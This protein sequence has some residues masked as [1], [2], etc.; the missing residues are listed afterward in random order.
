MP[1]EETR[2]LGVQRYI[3]GHAVEVRRDGGRRLE[4]PRALQRGG[5]QRLSKDVRAIGVQ[6]PCWLLRC[7]PP[8][9]LVRMQDGCRRADDSSLGRSGGSAKTV[10]IDR[11]KPRIQD[12]IKKRLN[13]PRL[14]HPSWLASRRSFLSPR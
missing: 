13:L 7:S 6:L 8:P 3:R 12:E 1:R 4:L 11:Y 5:G 2:T 9:P 14:D 10:A